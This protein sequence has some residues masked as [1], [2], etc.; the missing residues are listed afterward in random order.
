M[1]VIRQDVPQMLTFVI[2]TLLSRQEP[3]LI[4]RTGFVG[5]AFAIIAILQDDTDP[6]EL[7]HQDLYDCDDQF[8]TPNLMWSTHSQFASS[9]IDF[10]RWSLLQYTRRPD[11]PACSMKSRKH[12]AA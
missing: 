2:L 10:P 5:I 4:S 9:K 8:K 12:I 7:L 3:Q 1:A 11:L 6:V